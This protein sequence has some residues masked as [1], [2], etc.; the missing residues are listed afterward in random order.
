[1]QLDSGTTGADE[2]VTVNRLSDR[3]FALTVTGIETSGRRLHPAFVVFVG[4]FWSRWCFLVVLSARCFPL[5]AASLP[6]LLCETV[7]SSRTSL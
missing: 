2:Q 3:A 7:V 1:V 5:F 6:L 4:D